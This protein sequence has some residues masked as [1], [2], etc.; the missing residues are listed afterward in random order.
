MQRAGGSRGAAVCIVAN[1]TFVSIIVRTG[2]SLLAIQRAQHADLHWRPALSAAE[3][4]GQCTTC[5]VAGSWELTLERCLSFS[6]LVVVATRATPSVLLRRSQV[7]KVAK[8]K[9]SCASLHGAKAHTSFWGSVDARVRIC[10]V[11]VI[12]FVYRKPRAFPS[13]HYFI[14]HV[15]CLDPSTLLA[16]SCC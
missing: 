14:L 3:E 4:G 15:M 1:D 16:C 6:F 11:V 8:V 10:S 5:A 13:E 12:I 9:K 7:G 2:G